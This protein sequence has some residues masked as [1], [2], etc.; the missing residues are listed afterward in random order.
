MA[1]SVITVDDLGSTGEIEGLLD[2]IEQ[3]A[4]ERSRTAKVG[5][6]IAETTIKDEGSGLGMPTRWKKQDSMVR[7]GDT[8]LPERVQVYDK[9]GYPS[10]VPTAALRYHLNKKDRLGNR[11]FFAKPPDDMKEPTYI[12]QTCEVCLKNGSVRKRFQDEID[13]EGHMDTFHPREWR[14]ILRR[15]EREARQG[16]TAKDFAAVLLSMSDKEKDALKALLGVSPAEPKPKA[17][18]GAAKCVVCGDYYVSKA[19]RAHTNGG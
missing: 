6:V 9:N 17:K 8:P 19:H 3:Q 16:A 10:M 7:M 13:Y 2:Q 11:K 5:D 15:E 12:E 14:S 4:K 1:D 18:R